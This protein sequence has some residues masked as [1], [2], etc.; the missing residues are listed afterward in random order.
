MPSNF[1]RYF[2]QETCGSE[3]F[4]KIAQL[5]ANT[6]SHRH[7]SE[8]VDDIQRLSRFPQNMHD[9]SLVY[10]Y[11]IETKVQSSQWRHLEEPRPKKAPQVRLNM[12]VLL[13][14][15]FDCNGLMQ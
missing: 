2:R 8:D 9:E 13:T 6:A 12:K 7:R 5:L 1:Y 3:Y 15:S 10:G 11:D 14:V 4:S